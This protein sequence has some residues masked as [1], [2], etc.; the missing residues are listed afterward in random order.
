MHFFL[1]SFFQLGGFF[2]VQ[3]DNAL[4]ED[5]VLH[6][7]DIISIQC[8]GST[9]PEYNAQLQITKLQLWF[10][11][12]FN[13]LAGNLKFFWGRRRVCHP[14]S[15]YFFL[16]NCSCFCVLGAGQLATCLFW[17]YKKEEAYSNLVSSTLKT[18]VH[19]NKLIKRNS[20]KNGIAILRGEH[21]WLIFRRGTLKKLYGSFWWTLERERQFWKPW[22]KILAELHY[23]KYLPPR[24]QHILLSQ[25]I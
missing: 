8:S 14:F 12:G 18:T 5:P 16:L 21:L 23:S 22:R 6:T 20:M 4:G 7:A 9:V 1:L 3:H 2:Q 25:M 11:S 17:H 15:L 10:H 19:D 13:F 24:T